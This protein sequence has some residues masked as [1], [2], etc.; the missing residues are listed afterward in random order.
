VVG[1]GID[2]MIDRI[3]VLEYIIDRMD[4]RSRLFV[5]FQRN[6]INKERTVINEQHKKPKKKKNG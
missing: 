1:V 4:S 3:V 6:V 5:E 2:R